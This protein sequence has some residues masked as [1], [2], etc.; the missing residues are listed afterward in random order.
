MFLTRMGVNAKFVITGDMSQ[1][2]LPKRSDSGLI[3]AFK[4]LHHIKGD[5]IRRIRQ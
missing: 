5:C 3:H 4:L 1:I 2:D